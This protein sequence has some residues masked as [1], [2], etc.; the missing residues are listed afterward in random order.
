MEM[1]KVIKSRISQNNCQLI[2]F[3]NACHE[4][5]IP[6]NDGELL[7]EFKEEKDAIGFFEL[8][9]KSENIF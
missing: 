8:L 1:P 9:E 7:I 4:I 6:T 2:I 3:Q 5:I